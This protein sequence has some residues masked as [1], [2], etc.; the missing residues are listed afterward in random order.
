[1]AKIGF[2]GLGIMGLP[3]AVNLVK[4]SGMDIT[5][6][7]FLPERGE[8]LAKEGG[9]AAGDATA[10]AKDS[11]IIFLC[12]PSNEL[13]R[14]NCVLIA[15][16]AKAGTIVV[17]LSST[18]PG[19][20]REQYAKLREK[21][22]SLLDSP[23]S[24]GDV[25][26]KAGTLAIMCGGD[27]EVFEKVKPLLLMMGASAT[28]MGTTGCGSVAKLANNMIAGVHLAVLGEAFA[29]A[30]KAGLDPEVLFDAIR[31]GFAG[32][33]IMEA[34]APKLIS[35][36]YTPAARVAVHQKDLKNAAKL[37]ADMGVKIPLAQIVLDQMNELESMGLVNEDHCAMAK[38]YERDMGVHIDK[39]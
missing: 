29:F 18:A 3:M 16:N 31:V 20:V 17:D 13:V 15:G 38:L 35:G 33:P 24:G 27:K 6:L 11:E 12:L 39:K 30:V 22:I 1:M 37:A 4:K 8:L 36:D 21:G 23:V 2:I 19:V 32:S 5:G 34:K 7:D 26:A 25:G 28:Y 9:F 10:L 14:E